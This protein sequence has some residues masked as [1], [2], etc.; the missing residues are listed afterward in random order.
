MAC[1]HADMQPVTASDDFTAF[2]AGRKFKTNLADPPW[3]FQ[4]RTGKVAPE[5]KR[6]SRYRTLTLADIMQLP[7]GAVRRGL[8]MKPRT[9][10][11]A[12]SRHC[13]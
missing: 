6:L 13:A 2:V 8:P 9:C 7:V 3:Q 11:G 1:Y 5:H 12:L 4:N 10:N